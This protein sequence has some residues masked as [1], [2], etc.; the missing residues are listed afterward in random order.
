MSGNIS[1]SVWLVNSTSSYI[2]EGSTK[3][4]CNNSNFSYSGGYGGININQ[5]SNVLSVSSAKMLWR[6]HP[7]EEKL[8]NSRG[9]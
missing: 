4:S 1:V 2:F 6:I 5:V 8:I 9:R 7:E 3:L